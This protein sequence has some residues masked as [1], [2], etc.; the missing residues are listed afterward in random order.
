[1]R[2]PAPS[3]SDSE[4]D[5]IVVSLL[6]Q[7]G[8]LTEEN[9]SR[10]LPGGSL[11]VGNLRF[12]VELTSDTD[13][14][15]I[16]NYLPYDRTIRSR[17]GYIWKWDLEPLVSRPV[18]KGYDRVFT[19]LE[20]R[21]DARVHTA[22]PLLDWWVGKTYDELKA[23]TPPEKTHAISAIASTKDWIP[24]HRQRNAIIDT[25]STAVPEIELFGQ[26]RARQLDDK[27]DGLA[28]Y[29]YSIAIENT[30]KP[31]YWTEKIADCF[32]SY[33]VPL[34][35]GAT[36]ITDYFPE[37]SIIWLP[38][39]DPDEAIRIVRHT[40]EHDSFEKR[41]PALKEARRRMLEQYSLFGQLSLRIEAER[42]QILASPRV[43]TFVHGR[44]VKKGGWIRGAGLGG[45]LSAWWNRREARRGS[46]A[47][48][49]D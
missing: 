47:V 25:L 29:R 18:V 37:E 19:H 33:T 32:L 15:V 49:E 48:S 38:I 28:P 22:P 24:G 10:R 9:L 17:K 5:V 40:L 2:V 39:D 16:Q 46:K 3:A 21:G 30:S 31:D 43:D 41:Q 45:N 12:T 11:S 44:R 23:M 4:H 27:W 7:R 35:Y 36:N 13:V 34:Y 20:I 1:M 14:V 8:W 6:S 26:G 42:G